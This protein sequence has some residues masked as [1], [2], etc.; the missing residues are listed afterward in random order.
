MLVWG[1]AGL[2]I[3]IAAIAAVVWLTR[4]TPAGA[5][6]HSGEDVLRRRYA[7][8]EIDRDEFMQRLRDLRNQ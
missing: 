7:V 2:A 6:R 8:G 5:T 1:L 4:Q 3:L